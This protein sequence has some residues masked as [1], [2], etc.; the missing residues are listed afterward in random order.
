MNRKERRRLGV[1][2]NEEVEVLHRIAL[3]SD[4]EIESLDACG[5]KITATDEGVQ[6]DMSGFFEKTAKSVKQ[7]SF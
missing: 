1:T 6:I 5:A 4:A 3:L 7:K 2:T